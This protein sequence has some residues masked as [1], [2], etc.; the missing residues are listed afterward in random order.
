V[1]EMNSL[2]KSYDEVSYPVYAR[3]QTHPDRLFTLATLFGMNPTPLDGCRVLEVGGGDG[4]N[5]IPMAFD[6]NESEFLGLEL[7]GR[8]VENGQEMIAALELKNITLRQFDLMNASRDL[9]TFD[10]IIAHGVYS[11]TPPAVSEK[12]FALCDMCLAPQGVAYISYNTYPGGHL[13]EML[14]EMMLFHIRDFNDP[15]EQIGQ[16]RALVNFLIEAQTKRDEYG[17]FLKQERHRFNTYADAHLFHDDLES[18]YHPILFHEFVERAG[19]HNLRFLAEAEFTEMGY[20]AFDSQTCD[21]IDRL[22]GGKIELKEQYTDFLKC[23]SFRQTLLCRRETILDDNPQ[24]DRIK[25]LRIAWSTRL[26][27]ATPDEI[28]RKSQ[29]R[30]A[31]SDPLSEMMIA[32]LGECWPRSLSFDE[33]FVRVTSEAAAKSDTSL[34]ARSLCEAIWLAYVAGYVELRAHEPRFTLDISLRPRASDV[35]RLQI[36][37]GASVVTNLRHDNVNMDDELARRLILLLDGTRD[38]AAITDNLVALMESGEVEMEEN[39]G[40]VTDKERAHR[41]I[42][43]ALEKRFDQLA[44]L[45]LLVE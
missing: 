24:P 30:D 3:P 14:R 33:L 13:R 8:A 26:A 45:S 41:I 9:G 23:R 6:L 4:G 11:W 35:A 12:L 28:R 20:C 34:S 17:D 38:R 44:R 32:H 22:A 27:R 2:S 1:N 21:T 7:S 42:A 16:A 39:S 43:D 36:R 37:R 40:Q 5:L 18:E 29:T 15:R 19:A 31:I 10:Y 25:N